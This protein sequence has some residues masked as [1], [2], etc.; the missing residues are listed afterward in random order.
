MKRAR[1][2]ERRHALKGIYVK[3]NVR[4]SPPVSWPPMSRTKGQ[5]E[6]ETEELVMYVSMCPFELAELGSETGQQNEDKTRENMHLTT[7]I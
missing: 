7:L 6:S 3:K 4:F 1:T 2:V 5:T